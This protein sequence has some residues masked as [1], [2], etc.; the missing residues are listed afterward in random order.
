LKPGL[1][2][3]GQAAE[4]DD[5]V[6]VDCD[7]GGHGGEMEWMGT[8]IA[9]STL[10]IR[11]ALPATHFSPGFVPASIISRVPGTPAAEGYSI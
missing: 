3:F 8:G 10:K 9:K 6:A 7:G 4:V 5:A 2:P 1:E 11:S